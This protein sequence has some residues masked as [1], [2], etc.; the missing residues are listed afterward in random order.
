MHKTGRTIGLLALVISSVSCGTIARQGTSPTYLVMDSLIGQPGGT[1]GPFGNPVP[2]DVMSRV[3]SPAPC[4]ATAPCFTIF[5]DLGQAVIRAQMKDPLSP[6]APTPTNDVTMIR[7]HVSYRR[8]DGRNTEGV[9]VPFAFDG[10]STATIRIGNSATLPFEL[11]RQIAKA[12]T[13]LVNLVNN[14][15]VVTTIARVTFY[16]RD[17]AGNTV[18]VSGEITVDFADYG[19][20]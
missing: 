9:D 2:S 10:A 3:T 19:S 20:N 7:Y 15:T 13:P 5:P 18:S 17:Q 6:I 12:E 4:T 11:V 14:L 8:S 1:G 16:G